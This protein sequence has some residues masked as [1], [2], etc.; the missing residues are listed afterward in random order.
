MDATDFLRILRH[1]RDNWDFLPNLCPRHSN[2]PPWSSHVLISPTL[3]KWKLEKYS[4]FPL[5]CCCWWWQ[6]T[7]HKRFI[8][9]FLQP[10]TTIV[11]IS[12]IV[13]SSI[14]YEDPEALRHHRWLMMKTITDG[15]TKLLFVTTKK[16]FKLFVCRWHNITWMNKYLVSLV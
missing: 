1:L 8:I 7:L 13:C 9:I 11:R 6:Q 5:P 14:Y 3:L 12:R 4:P 10:P 15:R 2:A 16:N